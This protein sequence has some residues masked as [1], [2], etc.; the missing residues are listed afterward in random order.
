MFSRRHSLIPSASV[1]TLGVDGKP[2]GTPRT[3]SKVS[4]QGASALRFRLRDT[5]AEI[6]VADYF[7][8]TRNKALQFPHLPCIEVMGGALL[9]F[10]ICIVPPGQIMRRQVPPELTKGV[11]DFATKKPPERLASIRAG[12]EVRGI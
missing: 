9:P 8:R 2:M 7:K 10:E 1:Q 3:I 6:S 11:L 12:L 4:T 5:S